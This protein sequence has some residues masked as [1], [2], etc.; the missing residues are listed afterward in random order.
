MIRE[1]TPEEIESKRPAP[2]ASINAWAS[3]RGSSET[4]AHA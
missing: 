3:T 2:L 4:A 1:T